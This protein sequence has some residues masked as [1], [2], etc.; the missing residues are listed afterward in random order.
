MNEPARELEHL[1]GV[2][3]GEEAVQLLF[4]ARR[5]ESDAL[6]VLIGRYLPRFRRW[7]AARVPSSRESTVDLDAFLRSHLEEAARNLQPLGIRNEA[8]LLAHLRELLGSQLPAGA[9]DPASPLAHTLGLPAITNYEA[10]LSR[11]QPGERE[12]VIARIELGYGYA[13]LARILDKPSPNAARTLVIDAVR[14]VS[15]EMCD[16]G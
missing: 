11:L 15:Q 16:E 14:K 3:D 10:A 13:E 6:D 4:R 5:E 9:V 2:L 1:D 12:A 8:S 7:W